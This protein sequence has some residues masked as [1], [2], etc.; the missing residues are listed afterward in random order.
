MFVNSSFVITTN[1]H[2]EDCGM[3]NNSAHIW[4]L[5]AFQIQVHE[6]SGLIP[7]RQKDIKEKHLF[8]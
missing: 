8:H 1:E 3:Q 2:L 5:C 7:F 6:H 4:K